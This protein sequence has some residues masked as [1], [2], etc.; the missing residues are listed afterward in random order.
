MLQITLTEEQSRVLE[1]AQEIVEIRDANGKLITHV[2]PLSPEDLEM[3]ARSKEVLAAR[4][5]GVPSAQVQ[6]HFRR[7]TE[8]AAE[9]ELSK[10]EALDLIRRMR[11]GERV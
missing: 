11:D 1:Q 8:I 9:R 2:R 4:E 7:L 6:A 3:I 5:P 10:E